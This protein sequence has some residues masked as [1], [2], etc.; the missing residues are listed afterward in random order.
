MSATEVHA[1][2]PQA[3]DAPAPSRRADRTRTDTDDGR[4]F[5][6]IT[7]ERLGAREQG[8]DLANHWK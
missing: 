2:P 1:A 3:E 4:A 7:P 5:A 6:S 8:A